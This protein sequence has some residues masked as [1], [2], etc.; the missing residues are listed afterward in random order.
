MKAPATDL[1]AVEHKIR[2]IADASHVDHEKL[3]LELEEH[4]KAVESKMRPLPLVLN[5]ETRCIHKVL[6]TSDEAGLK[7]RATCSW[8]YAMGQFRLCSWAEG[9]GLDKCGTCY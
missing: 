9:E 2:S 1:T 7:A 6:T 8:K 5:T 3:R 4:I